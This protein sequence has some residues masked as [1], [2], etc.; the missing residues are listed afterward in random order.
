MLEDDGMSVDDAPLDDD[1]EGAPR[2]SYNF[3]PGYHG[4][5]YRGVTPDWGAGPRDKD[6]AREQA[7]RPVKDDGPV[8]YKMQSMKWG[9]VP[10]WTKRN[11]NYGAIMRTIN[12]RD[13]S[14]STPGGMW[15][16]MKTRKR[17]SRAASGRSRMRTL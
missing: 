7:D 8:K 5:V 13:D 10:F 9:L 3:A 16:S 12:C 1:G 2:S 14:L 6:Q 15:A 11:P 4:I 17:S